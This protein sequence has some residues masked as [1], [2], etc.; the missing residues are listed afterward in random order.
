MGPFPADTGG[1]PTDV[2]GKRQRKI[3][4]CMP[5]EAQTAARSAG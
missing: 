2:T 5:E 3:V 1:A 4:F